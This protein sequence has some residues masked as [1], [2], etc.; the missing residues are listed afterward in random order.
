MEDFLANNSAE[1][2]NMK[3]IPLVKKT[4]IYQFKKKTCPKKLENGWIEIEKNKQSP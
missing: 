2:K 4:Q 1:N 3:Q